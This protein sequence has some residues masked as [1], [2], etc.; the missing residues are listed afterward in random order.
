MLIL[1]AVIV[2]V[3]VWWATRRIQE[4]VKAAREEAA[5]GR[6]LAILDLFA[7][8]I[9]AARADPRA[10]LVWQPLARTARLLLPAEFAL[11]DRT[12]G[13]TFPFDSEHIQAAHAQWTADWLAW[14]R[15]HDAEFKLK[16]A[17]VE[18]ELA[19]SGGSP[20]IRAK[21]DAVEREKL[22]LYQRRYE[23]YVRTARSLQALL[24]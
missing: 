4:Q 3:A 16:A 2:A 21:L 23:E 14:E 17:E 15:A 5:R 20:V 10:L 1:A 18:H 8:G 22:D 9:A 13:A 12:A 11:L 6:A 19:A 24:R 7:P